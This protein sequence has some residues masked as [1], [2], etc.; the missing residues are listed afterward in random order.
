MVHLKNGEENKTKDYC[1]VCFVKL[2][3]TFENLVK[4][5]PSTPFTIQQKTPL[6]VLHRRTVATREK[7][8]H[9]LNMEPLTKNH[10]NGKL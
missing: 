9:S 8:I 2:Q 4:K 5:L 6:R 1:A 3:D 10:R 7:I